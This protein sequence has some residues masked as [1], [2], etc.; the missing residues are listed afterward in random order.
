VFDIFIL[1][2]G[3]LG[4]FCN[5]KNRDTSFDRWEAK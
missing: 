5:I 3:I 1:V 4:F 2:G